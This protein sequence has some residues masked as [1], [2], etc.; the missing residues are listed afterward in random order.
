MLNI[1]KRWF[2]SFLQTGENNKA[3]TGT[4]LLITTFGDAPLNP[5]IT[6]EC[7]LKTQFIHRNLPV[8]RSSEKIKKTV[9]EKSRFPFS[10]LSYFSKQ[11]TTFLLCFV[12]I[13]HALSTYH[14]TSDGSR[15]IVISH[16]IS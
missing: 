6:H 1:L 7:I 12:L 13:K 8:F 9:F 11:G 5:E 15:K 14:A 3:L 4:A 2:L 16:P 10:V